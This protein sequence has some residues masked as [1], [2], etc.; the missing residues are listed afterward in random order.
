[1]HTLLAQPWESAGPL[2]QVGA[3]SLDGALSP[4]LLSW[5][6]DRLMRLKTLAAAE[7]SRERWDRAASLRL[8]RPSPPIS[9]MS[10]RD[11]GEGVKRERKNEKGWGRR[12]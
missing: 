2:L 6:Q 1:M 7:R 8:G 11:S 10:I 4:S 9:P 12:G 5:V 3:G